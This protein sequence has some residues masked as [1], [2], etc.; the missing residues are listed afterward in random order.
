MKLLE[1]LVRRERVSSRLSMGEWLAQT[2]YSF[3]GNQYSLPLQT[4]M[5]GQK[6]E[7]ITTSFD[8]YVSGGL[9]GNGVVF[10]LASTRMRVFSEARFQF[11]ELRQGRPGD[12]FSD[13]S[14]GILERPWPGGTTGDLLA[15]MELIA[16]FAGNFYATVTNGEVV[17][18]RPDWV[19]ILLT[20]Q[21][22]PT[23]EP[24]GYRKHGYAYYEGGRAQ[25]KTPTVL[26]LD[27]VVHYAPQPD[28]LAS[29]RGMSWLTPVVREIQADGAA[30]AHKLAFLENA[31]TPNLAV[32][33]PKE[34]TPQQFDEFVELMSAKHDGPQFAGK[35]LYTGGGADVTVIGADMRQ[36]DFKVT[37]GAGETRLAQAAGVPPTVAGLSEGMQGSS[38]NAGNFGQARRQFADMTLSNLWRNAAGSLEVLV[39]P[40]PGSRLWYDT[41]D[42]PFLREDQRDAADIQGVQAQSIRTLLDAGYTADSVVSAV[43]NSDWKLLAHSGLFSV[44]LQAPGENEPAEPDEDDLDDLGERMR[45]LIPPTTFNVNIP[46]TEV[47]VAQPDAPVNVIN[48]EP[49]QVRVDAPN[50]RVDAPVIQPPIVN[51]AAPNVQ[52][53]A[54]VVNVAAPNVQVDAPVTVQ[55]SEVV[56]TDPPKSRRVVRDSKGN[57]TKIVE[58]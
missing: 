26:D 43:N 16:Q 37:Q 46:P 31:A 51:V 28:P 18:L 20:D 45:S 13:P 36:L 42:I 11:Q 2:V 50:V 34:V 23:G 33:L 30:T 17:I 38:L 57:I 24:I 22:L 25:G 10:G 54:P 9:Y 5:Q 19:E 7:A 56:V 48:L 15:R 1:P 35:T 8:G 39:P 40:P 12:L 27:E 6:A 21:R 3:G 41:R 47:N 49:A 55:P 53:D 52:V 29:Y 58:E 4:T 32:S 14:L 44:Q